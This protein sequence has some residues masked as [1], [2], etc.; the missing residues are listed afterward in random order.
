MRWFA[1]LCGV[2]GAGLLAGT[3]YFAG[4][5]QVPVSL[6]LMLGGSPFSHLA[7]LILTGSLVVVILLTT[8]R[9]PWRRHERPEA[10]PDILIAIAV[11]AP[12]VGL[13]VGAYVGFNIQQPATRL[14][15]TNVMVIAPTV[16]E[17]L[18]VASVGLLVG[19]TAAGL[20][21]ALLSKG[22]SSA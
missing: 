6:E 21:A 13:L 14:H 19:A 9:L 3:Y 10:P 8:S 4:V 16:A 17:A 15:V 5:G 2:L 12:S 11:A 1:L 22:F 7:Y 20:I 18:L